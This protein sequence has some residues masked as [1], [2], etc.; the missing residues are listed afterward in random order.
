MI[1][2][3]ETGSKQY[4]VQKGDVIYT[5]KIDAKI[6]D[7]LN[8]NKVYYVSGK[9]GNPFVKGA[10]VSCSVEKHGKQKKITIIKHKRYS[11]YLKRQGHRQQYTKL[12]VTDINAG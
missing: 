4:K 9:I 7:I 10:F 6:G 12:V 2:V 5:E 11:R 8:F 1:T 3:F